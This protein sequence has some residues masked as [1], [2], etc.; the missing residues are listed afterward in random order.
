MHGIPGPRVLNEGDII[1]LDVGATYKGFVGDAAFTVGVGK[2]G[3]EAQ[4]LIDVTEQ[5]L[6]VG[7][8]GHGRRQR[9][10]RFSMAIQASRSRTAIQSCRE[11][12]GHGVGRHMHE[13]TP[14][15][16]LVA[17]RPQAEIAVG[18]ATRC[19]PA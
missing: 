10:Q 7:I 13:E 19:N 18:A 9:N 16:E 8:K 2:I 17:A 5:A 4:K 1:S 12:T 3:P 14:D 6:W 15:P 11:Y